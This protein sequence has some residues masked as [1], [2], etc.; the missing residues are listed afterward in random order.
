IAYDLEDSEIISKV[1][2]GALPEWSTILTTQSY[3][4]AMQFQSAIRYHEDTLLSLNGMPAVALTRPHSD[5]SKMTSRTYLVGTRS[6]LPPPK[7]PKDDSNVSKRATPE[8]KG[9]RPCRLCGSGKHWDHECK[10]NEKRFAHVRL[11][12]TSIDNLQAEDEYNELY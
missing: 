9:A 11:C 8:S 1:M 4:M 5:R 7:F 6:D 10:H 12:E 3:G 2:E